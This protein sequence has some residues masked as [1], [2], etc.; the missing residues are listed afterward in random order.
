MK[1]AKQRLI[2]AI[3]SIVAIAYNVVTRTYKMIKY[4]IPYWATPFA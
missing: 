2:N 3:G 1:I 4:G